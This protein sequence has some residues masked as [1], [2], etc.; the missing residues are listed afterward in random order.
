EPLDALEF[1][2]EG[3]IILEG[4]AIDDFR[5]AV[6]PEQVAH[7]PDIAIT[8]A[9]DAFHHPI[10]GNGWSGKR[11]WSAGVLECWRLGRINRAAGKLS[12]AIARGHAT[13]IVT[14]NV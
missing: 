12:Q 8:A 10:I 11:G 3:L 6:A 13:C 1:P 7:Q 2:F 5:R 4:L 14:Q 9:A